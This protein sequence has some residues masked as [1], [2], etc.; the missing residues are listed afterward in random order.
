MPLFTKEGN[1]NILLYNLFDKGRKKPLHY[2]K[3]IFIDMTHANLDAAVIS[4]LVAI[5]GPLFA[6][7]TK[8]WI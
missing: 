4:G 2:P 5:S 7:R 6:Y 1:V 8:H 3:T